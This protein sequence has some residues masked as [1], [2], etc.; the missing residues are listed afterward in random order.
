MLNA[1]VKINNTMAKNDPYLWVSEMFYSV[2]GEG[3]LTGAP[4]VFLRLKGCNLFCGGKDATWRCD[5]IEVW[6][7]G[8]KKTL[9]ELLVEWEKRGFIAHIKGGA[10]IVITGGEP[11]L[12][13]K[14]LVP[15]FERLK[16]LLN[17]RLPLIEIE[18]NGTRIP[19]KHLL[20]YSLRYNVSPKLQNSGMSN[21]KRLK[22]EVLHWFS[23]HPS[24]FFKFVVRSEVDV[25]EAWKTMVRPFKVSVQRVYLMPAAAT[26]TELENRL[27][28][29]VEF[30]KKY[31]CHVSTRL[32]ISIWD[33]VT[34]V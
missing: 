3:P 19:T 29:V 6:Q 33:Q 15:F 4:S 1:N 25:E 12:Q 18:T 16:T 31:R 23:K 17:G 9:S 26:R 30:A 2:Q 14:A 8:T 21:E 32:H 13:D 27:P 28:R 5:T 34:G 10:N 7:K 11:L 20:S 22:P 24:S